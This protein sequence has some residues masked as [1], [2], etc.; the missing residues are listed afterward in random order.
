MVDGCTLMDHVHRTLCSGISFSGPLGVVFARIIVCFLLIGSFSAVF[1]VDT[2]IQRV[3]FALS[4]AAFVFI[5]KLILY[6]LN[7][8]IDRS[9]GPMHS[10]SEEEEG[11][12]E[13]ESEE[14]TAQKA[15][16]ENTEAKEKE[17]EEDGDDFFFVES[18]SDTYYATR[19]KCC[20]A[21]CPCTFDRRSLNSAFAGNLSFLYV[22]TATLIV[23][24]MTF[25]STFIL[26]DMILGNAIWGIFIIGGAVFS[27]LH[28]PEREPYSET[29]L[30]PYTGITRPYAI[31][32]LSGIWK[33]SHFLS[34][35]IGSTSIDYYDIVINWS[36]VH[37]YV[38]FVCKWGINLFPL[39]MFFLIGHTYTMISW[40]LEWL[41][42]YLFGLGGSTS[43]LHSVIQIVRSGL[44]ATIYGVV[45]HYWD[46]K[47]GKDLMI[48]VSFLLLQIP[49]DYSLQKPKKILVGL[50][51][52]LILSLISFVAA[53]V[54]Q[55]IEYKIC[56]YI[57]MSF[58]VIFDLVW[59]CVL[60]YHGY[61][62]VRLKILNVHSLI[63]DTIRELTAA[64]FAPMLLSSL[65]TEEP[66][67]PVWV[68][69]LILVCVLNRAL[70]ESHIFAIGMIIA[71][72]GQLSELNG[73]RLSLILLISMALARKLFSVVRML[74]YYKKDTTVVRD[75][76]TTNI[77]A[78]LTLAGAGNMPSTD[79]MMSFPALVWSLITGAPMTSFS[80]KSFVRFPSCPRPNVFWHMLKKSRSYA[81]FV[82][83]N[84]QTHPYETW[85]YSGAFLQLVEDLGAL[86]RSGM[87]GIVDSNDVLLFRS[88]ECSFFVHVISSEPHGV[89]FQ[90]RGLEI[91]DTTLCH[92]L[93]TAFVNTVLDLVSVDRPVF[94]QLVSLHRSWNVRNLDVSL[95]F[96]SIDR[97]E[98]ATAFLGIDVETS[99]T[100]AMNAFAYFMTH[101]TPERRDI[102]RK[103]SIPT[104]AFYQSE[105]LSTLLEEFTDES[106]QLDNEM[107]AKAYAIW[108]AFY[109]SIF[110][111]TEPGQW[112]LQ[113]LVDLFNGN[114]SSLPDAF[115]EMWSAEMAVEFLFPLAR[116]TLGTCTM[117]SL[118]LTPDLEEREEVKAF[119][120]TMDVF[121]VAL[122]TRLFWKS[123]M[124]NKPMLSLSGY[125]S[126][127]ALVLSFGRREHKFSVLAFQRESVRSAWACDAY[128]QGFWCSSD[129]E[130][131]NIQGNLDLH[132]LII[133]AGNIP[134]GYPAFVSPIDTSYVFPPNFKLFRE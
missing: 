66:S 77:F 124:E 16:E 101:L 22:L 7:R 115:V 28:P 32:V 96:W 102:L 11:E 134:F 33:I 103:S 109:T 130:R 122:H 40:V 19:V 89:S 27:S 5:F 112:Q 67:C 54:G 9:V 41:G 55:Y 36:T 114:A 52:I 47:W 75:Q 80:I 68:A 95:P 26:Q 57:V 76:F 129:A 34:T 45:D 29:T 97:F 58:S 30:D 131:A 98:L 59:P 81:D 74:E 37:E 117:A 85:V 125:E 31:L 42:R 56:S 51:V 35:E 17:E 46:N 118:L 110:G 120:S 10:D 111:D 38:D 133:Q 119:F 78:V 82:F 92:E 113:V 20:G 94:H 128:L 61:W 93:E 107:T 127:D 84:E 99:I 126:N 116:W 21:T 1:F 79:R 105:K 62:I 8:F 50:L 106:S 4:I 12:Q 90:I 72:I 65:F 15:E 6:I 70:L 63:V 73:L 123:I 60:T 24:L 25:T 44:T 43:L 2:I 91:E 104:D 87:L 100:W 18:S 88:E 83:A 132:N 14:N 48:A 69:S 64:W 53:I 71:A 108:Y 49:L 121:A 39:W 23:G 86:V 13:R 3:V